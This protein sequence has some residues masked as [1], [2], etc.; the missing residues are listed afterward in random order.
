MSGIVKSPL[1]SGP[2][3]TPG[4]RPS[5]PRLR[6]WRPAPG[7]SPQEVCRIT[8]GKAAWARLVPCRS[9]IRSRFQP[10]DPD[11]FRQL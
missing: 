10:D 3:A 1:A 2:M 8:G 4:C 11:P 5:G 6:N 7:R 9:A